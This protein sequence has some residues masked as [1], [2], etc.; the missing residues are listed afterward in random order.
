MVNME[1]IIKILPAAV[2]G[3]ILITILIYTIFT[4]HLMNEN[5]K[6]RILQEKIN[7]VNQFMDYFRID[8]FQKE[9][10]REGE[11]YGGSFTLLDNNQKTEIFN[12]IEK[13]FDEEY[14]LMYG[15]N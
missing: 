6:I 13:D 12:E 14:N 5:T 4:K 1:E 8:N 11:I 15:N 10:E 3:L 9:L 7:R 2:Q